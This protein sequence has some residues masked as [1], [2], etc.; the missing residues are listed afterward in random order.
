MGG[1]GSGN[2][3]RWGTRAVC[4]H[5]KRIDIRYLRKRGMLTSG[6][7][8]S[9]SWSRGDESA[10]YIRYRAH[11]ASL[12]LDYKFSDGDGEWRSV[13]EHVWLVKQG[14]P[15]GGFRKF[16]LCP[17]CHRRC[18][19]LYGGAY[20][21]CR[22]CYGLAY[23]SQ[24]EDAADR[25]RRTAEKIRVRLGGT[26]DLDEPFPEKPKGMHWKTYQ[27]LRERGERLEAQWDVGLTYMMARL[28]GML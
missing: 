15:Y 7:M 20:F 21:R 18:M 27:R 26:A 11:E 22:K 10:G 25:T 12:E 8:G 9:L 19:V 28:V 23:A 3:L 4:E 17:R 1:P 2:S 24:N 16:F 13:N 5:Q 6:S 14:Q